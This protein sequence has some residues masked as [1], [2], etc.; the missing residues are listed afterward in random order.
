[1]GM[2]H[3]VPRALV[4]GEGRQCVVA[5]VLVGLGHDPDGRVGD[6]LGF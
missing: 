5:R 3:D 4:D 2:I 6:S 1:M